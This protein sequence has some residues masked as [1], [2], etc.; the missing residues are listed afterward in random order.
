MRE[1]FSVKSKQ[2][3]AQRVG[4]LCSSPDCRVLTVG[5]QEANE[6]TINLGVAAHITAASPGGPRFDDQLTP[7]ERMDPANGIWLCQNCAKL[8]DSG[9]P[10]FESELLRAWKRVAEDRA[11]VA[12]GRLS[13]QG[14]ETAEQKLLRAVNP[15]IGKKVSLV[16]MRTGSAVALLGP[17]HGVSEVELLECNEFF[18]TVLTGG[19]TRRS[20]SLA[21]ISLNFDHAQGRLQLQERY[22]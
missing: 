22:D 5:P 6:A 3:L 4:F 9:D 14:T 10:R 7:S 8:I 15:W 16:Q 20:I 13:P 19:G 12:L 11:A 18:I 1:E 2:T 21:Q 17:T